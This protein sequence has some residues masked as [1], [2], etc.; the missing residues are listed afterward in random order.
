MRPCQH[1]Q[2]RRVG[3]HI[4]CPQGKAQDIENAAKRA[5][6]RKHNYPSADEVLCEGV[7]RRKKR[8][9]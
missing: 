2:Q 1:C 5:F 7:K 4:D 6:L 9:G 8:Y 3:C